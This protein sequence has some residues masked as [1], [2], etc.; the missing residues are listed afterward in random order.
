MIC[1]IQSLATS[2]IM[3]PTTYKAKAYSAV[4]EKSPL[5]STTIARR[6][7]WRL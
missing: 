3:Q 6:D 7:P 4:S 5:A 2:F 1:D